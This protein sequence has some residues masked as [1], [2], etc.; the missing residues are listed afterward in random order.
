MTDFDELGTKIFNGIKLEIE[1][2]IISSAKKDEE[3]VIS[4]NGKIVRVSA[5]EFLQD[6]KQK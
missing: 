6:Q 3:L 5:K 4:K 1:R 2:L